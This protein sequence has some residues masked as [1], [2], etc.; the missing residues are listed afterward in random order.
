M[1]TL[2][3]LTSEALLLPI[4]QRMALAH[5]L[6][7]SFEPAGDPE[8]KKAWEEEIQRRIQD[9]DSGKVQGIPG[10]Q[11]FAELDKTLSKK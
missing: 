5:E 1:K 8:V 3:A 11:V 2:E 4:E 7:A 10:P 9:Y 6:L